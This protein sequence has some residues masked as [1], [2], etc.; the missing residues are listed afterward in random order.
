MS[1][2]FPMPTLKGGHYIM[3][4]ESKTAMEDWTN[5]TEVQAVLKQLEHD[6]L[7][8]LSPA[9]SDKLHPGISANIDPVKI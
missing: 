3:A 7:D 1:P 6:V 9:F 4:I 5:S 8:D 2:N